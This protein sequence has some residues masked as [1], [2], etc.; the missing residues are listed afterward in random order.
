M[1]PS[2]KPAPSP[3]SS[4]INALAWVFIALASFSTFISILQNIMIN[5]FFPLDQMH[6][7]MKEAQASQQM[8]AFAGFMFDNIRLFFMAFLLV[9]VSTLAAAIGLLKRWNWARICFIVIMVLAIA[10][11]ILGIILQQSFI[12][13][14]PKTMPDAPVDFRRHF[15]TMTMT[16]IIRIA[17]VLMAIAMSGLFGWI[18]KRLVSPVIRAE[19]S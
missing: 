11:N 12:T 13:S 3:Q 15:E 1:E 14:M 5:T 8:P 2:S 9:S 18:V 17:S 10:W 4:F 6:T 19:F 16:M 7:A